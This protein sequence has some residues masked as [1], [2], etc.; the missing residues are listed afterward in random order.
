MRGGLLDRLYDEG[1]SSGVVVMTAPP[2]YGKTVLASQWVE[3]D[4]RP[5]AW[6]TLDEAD[7]DPRVLV[8]YIVLALH[9]VQPVEPA[10]LTALSDDRPAAVVDTLLPQLARMAAS[11]Q[12]T[13]L[14]LDAVEALTDR[15]SLEVVRVLGTSLAEHCQLVLVGRAAPSDWPSLAQVG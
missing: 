15:R 3:E 9:R 10:V 8:A 7:N 5:F 4:P 1:G 12:P 13:V 6:V 14:V 11:R 2:G